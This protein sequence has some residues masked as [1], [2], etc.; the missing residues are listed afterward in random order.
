ML[1]TYERDVSSHSNSR[2]ERKNLST[3]VEPMTVWLLSPDAL[4]LS[5]RR[6]V[7]AKTNK[8]GFFRTAS[9]TG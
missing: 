5:H 8:L 2:L 9:V 4:P 1:L 7:G 3:G 6:L